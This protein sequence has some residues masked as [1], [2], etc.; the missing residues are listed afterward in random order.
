MKEMDKIMAFDTLFTNNR[1]Q[2]YKI[3]LSYLQP[4]AQ[5]KFAIYIKLMEL[6]YTISFF[7]NY[8]LAAMRGLPH[9]EPTNTA[10]IIDELLP[11]CDTS[12]KEQMK[13]LK[14]MLQNFENMQE[15][16]ETM[17]MMKELFPDGM[18]MGTDNGSNSACGSMDLSQIFSMFG[19]SD[20]SEM[21]GIF[22]ILNAFSSNPEKNTPES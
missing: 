13:N 3:L 9:E 15:M 22:D 8:P 11:F 1:I 18:G 17:Q 5:Q 21:S 2:M 7:Q 10:L 12:Q 19:S 20:M 14:I 6:Q 4:A 16:M